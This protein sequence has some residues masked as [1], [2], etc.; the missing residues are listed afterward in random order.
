[1]QKDDALQLFAFLAFGLGSTYDFTLKLYPYTQVTRQSRIVQLAKCCG[2]RELGGQSPP[3]YTYQTLKLRSFFYY[4]KGFYYIANLDVVILIYAD[5]AFVALE[6]F[7]G[8][9]LEAFERGNNAGM[10]NHAV[11]H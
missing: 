9:I 10:D 2:S 8:V 11:A 1:M 3:N 4:F 7:S 5:T 6:H